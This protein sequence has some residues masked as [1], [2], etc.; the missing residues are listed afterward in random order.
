MSE[1][2]AR[3]AVPQ[4]RAA[5]EPPEEPPTAYSGFQGLRVT[6]H[7]RE[8]VKPAQQNS[9]VVVRACTM[10]PGGQDA[11]RDDGGLVGDQVLGEQ[12]PARAGLAGDRHL[13]LDRHR[14]AG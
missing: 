12:R 14:D 9:G 6:P 4:A 8:C 13:V 11:L 7:R 2:V 1:P 10:P 5:P 3:V